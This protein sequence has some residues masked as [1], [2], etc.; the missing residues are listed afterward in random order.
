[1]DREDESELPTKQA[2]R[3][4]FRILRMEAVYFVCASIV[5]V[6]SPPGRQ[7]GSDAGGLENSRKVPNS[8]SDSMI[9]NGSGPLFLEVRDV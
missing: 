8:R 6:R 2:K 4:P 7:E 5:E 3:M 1:M 9:A